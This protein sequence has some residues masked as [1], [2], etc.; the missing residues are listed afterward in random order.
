MLK[1]NIGNELVQKYLFDLIE[2][3]IKEFDIDGW[4]LDVFNE[5]SYDFLRKV[6]QVFRV[7]KV[8][9][10]IFGENWDFLMFWLRGD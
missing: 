3:W 6:K 1:W 5:V 2:F 10:F 7:V 4:R 8:D 9:I